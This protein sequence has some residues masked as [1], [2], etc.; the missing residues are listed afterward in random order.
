VGA[1]VNDC[2]MNRDA[3]VGVLAAPAMTPRP[4]F[5]R[6]IGVVLALGGIWMLVAEQARI[7]LPALRWMSAATFPGEAVAGAL[8]L[9][10]GLTLSSDRSG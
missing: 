1:I 3:D 9:V 10:A 4:A 5:V 6:A 7:G 2:F 8:V